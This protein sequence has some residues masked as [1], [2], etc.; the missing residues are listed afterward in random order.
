MSIPH[1]SC[2]RG[3]DP[4]RDVCPW[5]GSCLFGP[6]PRAESRESVEPKAPWCTCLGD[7]LT[8]IRGR[9]GCLHNAHSPESRESVEHP[10]TTPPIG[11][12]PKYCLLCGR[13]TSEWCMHTRDGEHRLTLV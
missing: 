3:Q 13:V 4:C 12:T 11:E 5:A 8:H 9:L 6:P 1:P 10:K 2:I 7:T